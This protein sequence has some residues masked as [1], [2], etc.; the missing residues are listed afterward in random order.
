MLDFEVLNTSHFM[1]FLI[2]LKRPNG[3]GLSFSTLNTHRAG[4]NFLYRIY[5]VRKPEVLESELVN[6]FKSLK[7]RSARDAQNGTTER[8]TN[9][10]LPL[11]F[12][13][14]KCLARQFFM[15]IDANNQDD[16]AA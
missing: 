8:P 6:Y 2:T 4:F 11:P 12:A 14:Y 1:T 10:K 16:A 13:V 7:K 15:G 3:Q 9:T 5:S